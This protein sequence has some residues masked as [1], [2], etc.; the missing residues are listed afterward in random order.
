MVSARL[1]IGAS[2]YR[3]YIVYTVSPSPLTAPRLLCCSL[4]T[5][6]EAADKLYLNAA[7]LIDS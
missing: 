6:A 2:R 3:S 5:N 1:F 7:V 4:P